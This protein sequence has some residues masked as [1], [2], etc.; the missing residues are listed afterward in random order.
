MQFIYFFQICKMM[1]NV[2]PEVFFK[3]EEILRNQILVNTMHKHMMQQPPIPNQIERPLYK[4][5]PRGMNISEEM[6]RNGHLSNRQ[7]NQ[8]L[9]SSQ[10]SNLNSNYSQ[11]Y[12]G[13]GNSMNSSST[14]AQIIPRSI[15]NVSQKSQIYSNNM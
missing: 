8:Q 12:Q 13:T 3:Q 7:V 6:L 14:F 11:K 2:S 1:N 4:P 5:V 15:T 9:N 10:R